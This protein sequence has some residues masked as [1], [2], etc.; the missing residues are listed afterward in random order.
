[1]NLKTEFFL[2]RR[3][4][5][6]K[7]SAVSIITVISVIGVTL[8]VAVLIVVLAVMTGFT[9]VMKAKLLD[10]RAHL[11]VYSRYSQT[12]IDP[13]E[14]ITAAKKLGGRA[15]A[16]VDRPA[17]IQRK[18]N[19]VPKGIIGINPKEADKVFKL[20][21]QIKHGKLSLEHNEVI[22]S[23]IIAK[24]LNLWIGD[25]LIVHSPPRLAKMFNVGKDG[26][27]VLEKSDRIYL[28]EEYI[29]SAIYSFGKYDFDKNI[30]FMGLDDADELFE[31]PWGAASS[32]YI[33]TDE[34]FAVDDFR[35][36]LEAELPSKFD[37]KV[38]S[39][40]MYTWKE[41]NRDLL[42]VLQVEKNMMFFLMIFIVLV[43]AFSITNTLITIVYQKTR[44]IGLLKA[45]GAS[46]TSV[47]R[48]FIFQGFIVGVLG[49]GC[50][51][52]MGWLVVRY[53][54]NLVNFISKIAG[55]DLFPKEF[56]YFNELPGRIVTADLLIICLSAII[57]CTIGGIIPAWSAARQDPAKTLRNE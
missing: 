18:Q 22:I 2:A 42:G 30:I 14:V 36:K 3:Y 21:D 41:I 34:P 45:L 26:K 38:S 32:V 31:L 5:R 27:V 4:M 7:R 50:G 37:P 6:P 39:K 12:I 35:V 15:I 44:E 43:A 16:I 28:P 20:E 17:L 51:T 46:S 9:D 52:L 1:M 33:W 10:T 54:N 55:R 40:R 25:K 11:Q 47:M 13:Q 23:T 49:S 24:E 19:F 56:Y 29:I 53:R 57:L 48:I 8:G